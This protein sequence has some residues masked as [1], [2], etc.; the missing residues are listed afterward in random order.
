MKA[1]TFIQTIEE[2]GYIRRS[3]SE[4]LFFPLKSR[5][6]PVEMITYQGQ[7]YTFSNPGV[8]LM[9]IQDLE[10]WLNKYLNPQSVS[11]GKEEH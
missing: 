5:N 2:T 6:I 11:Q 3:Q 7:G 4:E 8:T 1:P 10:D 9:A